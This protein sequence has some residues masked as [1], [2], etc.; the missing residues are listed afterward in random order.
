MA[1]LSLPKMFR[2]YLKNLSIPKN[3]RTLK[4]NFEE[5]DGLGIR[6]RYFNTIIFFVLGSGSS[7]SLT[8]MIGQQINRLGRSASLGG[9][10]KSDHLIR[11]LGQ[12]LNMFSRFLNLQLFFKKFSFFCL[13]TGIRSKNAHITKMPI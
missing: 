12:A 2:V 9:P 11:I 13:S 7:Y 10:I 1:H 8:S 6:L 3:L 4:T 5:A